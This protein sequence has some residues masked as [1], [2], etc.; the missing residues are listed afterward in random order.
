MIPLVGVAVDMDVVRLPVGVLEMDVMGLSVNV[1]VKM[2]IH[3][4]DCWMFLQ[5]IEWQ[6]LHPSVHAGACERHMAFLSWN[7][8]D[9]S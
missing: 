8:P 9:V 5:K 7:S 3:L 4:H 1:P 2:D 6:L